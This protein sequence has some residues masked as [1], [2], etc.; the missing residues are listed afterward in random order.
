MGSA[1]SDL[2][3]MLALS[4]FIDGSFYSSAL[5]AFSASAPCSV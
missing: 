3:A 2:A 5:D 1:S 4:P